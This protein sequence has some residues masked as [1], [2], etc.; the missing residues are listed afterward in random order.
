MFQCLGDQQAAMLGQLCLSVGSAKATFGTGCFMLLNTG[1]QIVQS[2]HG[3]LTTVG[4]QLGA[5]EKCVY[6][7]EGSV[8]VAGS[9]IRWFRDELKFIKEAK[10]IDVLANTVKDAN[11]VYIVPA[12]SG[13]LSPYWR[14]DAR[15]VITGLTHSSNSGHLA[16]A[17]IEASAYQTSEVLDAMLRDTRGA[18]QLNELKVD[19]G[20]CA[21]EILMQFQADLLRIPVH[22][23]ASLEATASGAAFAAGLAT[24]FWSD[25]PSLV[26]AVS[27]KPG[28][29]IYRPD[30]EE[31]RRERLYRGWKKAVQRTFGWI[32]PTTTTEKQAVLDSLPDAAIHSPP[33]LQTVLTPPLRMSASPVLPIAPAPAT[34]TASSIAPA[35]AAAASSTIV[36][37]ASRRVSPVLSHLATLG[38]GLL[39]GIGIT[40]LRPQKR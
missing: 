33:I 5:K 32:E 26:A 38:F 30:M 15:G 2:T 4:F 23:P 31:E 29:R 22:R 3:L 17:I 34:P 7:L 25:M 6:A 11:D 39:L 21:S 18:V 35:A 1:D 14:D 16:R 20:M 37:A 12:F 36:H 24:G 8:A 19:G 27:H 40:M 9:G 10:E 13:L 28:T